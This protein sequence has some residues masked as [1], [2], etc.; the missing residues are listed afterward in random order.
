MKKKELEILVDLQEEHI[1]DLE[2]DI[3]LV[4]DCLVEDY[5]TIDILRKEGDHLRIRNNELRVDLENRV[6]IDVAILCVLIGAFC[7]IAIGFAIG[8]M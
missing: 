7:G 1:S 6:D 5:N 4:A 8:V 2:Y 3:V